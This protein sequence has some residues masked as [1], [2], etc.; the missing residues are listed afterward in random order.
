MDALK[1][2]KISHI[3]GELIRKTIKCF[4]FYSIPSEFVIAFC[5]FTGTY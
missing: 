5:F 1:Y 3:F 4:F 2:Y